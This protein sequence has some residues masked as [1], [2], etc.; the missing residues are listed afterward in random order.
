MEQYFF[1]STHFLRVF[2]CVATIGIIGGIGYTTYI[3]FN[4]PDV[5]SLKT[6]DPPSTALIELRYAEAQKS[7]KSPRRLQRWIPFDLISDHLKLAVLMAEKAYPLHGCIEASELP[8]PI[9][10]SWGSKLMIGGNDSITKHLAQN[11]YFPRS[12]NSFFDFREFMTTQRLESE[13]SKCRI[14][15][16]YLNVIEWGEGIW[17]IEA[18]SRAYFKIPAISLNQEQAALLAATLAN[19]RLHNPANP[20][21]RLLRRKEFI[22]ERMNEIESHASTP[23]AISLGIATEPAF[24]SK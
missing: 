22:L 23:A 1:K 4:L 18:A 21:K 19:P 14:F 15:E 12:D 13:L 10:T 20:S 16:I 17:G 6:I 2:W 7:G 8:K 5:H 9:E 24:Y 11:L 3:Y